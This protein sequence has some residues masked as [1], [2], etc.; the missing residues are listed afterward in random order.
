[1]N[2]DKTIYI[3]IPSIEDT[4]LIP[5]IL[6][7]IKSAKN[8]DRVFIGVGYSSDLNNIFTQKKLLEKFKKY[9]NV[10]FEFLNWKKNYGISYGRLASSKFYNDQDFFLQIDA[11]T[12]FDDCWDDKL[13]EMYTSAKNKI[14]EEKILL[15]GY[16]AH[17]H[18]NNSGQRV[19]VDNEWKLLTIEFNN[20]SYVDRIFSD[21]S[22]APEDHFG[23]LIP[24]WDDIS[25]QKLWQ[26]YDREFLYSAKVSGGFIFGDKD[27]G[28]DYKNMY[29]YKYSF[30]EEEVI[31]SIELFNL[32][33]KFV[34]PSIDVPVAHLYSVHINNHGGSRKFYEMS[35]ES[36]IK[37]KEKYLE[38]V[39][40]SYDKF[41][42]YELAM[43][44]DL[45]NNKVVGRINK[46]ES[47]NY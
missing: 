33:Y 12:L 25:P 43:G 19:L 22:Q 13:I 17:Y 35:H 14:G 32:G 4:E 3:A 18:Y 28:K 41:K 42:K 24:S 44:V 36:E 20:K 11:H 45:I 26:D 9:P 16:P 27:F 31:S 38:Y 1:M 40:K 39:S 37:Y 15:S 21:P 30:I 10:S 8:P 6:N 2:S 29:P 34:C 7:A 46:P 47:F 23:R 5:T